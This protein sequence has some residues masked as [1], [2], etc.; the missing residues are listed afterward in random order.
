MCIL[1]NENLCITIQ[2]W[3]KFI[4]KEFNLQVI[5]DFITDNNPGP[6]I[7]TNAG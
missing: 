3:L 2:I 5:I 7:W 4:P 6:I 1:L